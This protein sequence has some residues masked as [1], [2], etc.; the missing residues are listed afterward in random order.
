MVAVLVPRVLKTKFWPDN[1]WVPY[2][3]GIDM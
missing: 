1:T 2:T 3:A